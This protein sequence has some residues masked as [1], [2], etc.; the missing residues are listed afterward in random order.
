[1]LPAELVGKLF[2]KFTIGLCDESGGVPA[3]RK[4][5]DTRCAACW[6]SGF[7]SSY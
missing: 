5:E 4:V 1:M 7:R 6:G 3:F 2:E